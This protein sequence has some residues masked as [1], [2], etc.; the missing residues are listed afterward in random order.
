LE[1]WSLQNP[2]KKDTDIPANPPD[3]FDAHERQIASTLKV[4]LPQQ[5]LGFVAALAQRWLQAYGKLSAARGG[6]EPGVG[7]V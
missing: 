7:A 1:S 3:S 6:G 5:R 2:R 4:W